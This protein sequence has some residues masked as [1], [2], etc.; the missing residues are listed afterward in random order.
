MRPLWCDVETQDVVTVGREGVR[1]ECEG[2]RQLNTPLECHIDRHLT[3]GQQQQGE[4]RV[5]GSWLCMCVCVW[6]YVFASGDAVPCICLTMDSPLSWVSGLNLSVSLG[7]DSTPNMVREEGCAGR[8]LRWEGWS[9]LHTS[10]V[11]P[12]HHTLAQTHSW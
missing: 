6:V 7:L 3:T 12:P 4:G 10:S 1:T 8:I 11:S 5:N 9:H 2:W